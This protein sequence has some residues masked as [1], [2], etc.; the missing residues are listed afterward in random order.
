[1]IVTLTKEE[2]ADIAQEAY[3]YAGYD[4]TNYVGYYQIAVDADNEANNIVIA[5]NKDSSN[6]QH[7]YAIYVNPA[8][9][10]GYFEY[11]ETLDKQELAEKLMTIAQTY[12]ER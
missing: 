9:D 12:S 3:E 11:T 10:E 8:V 7:C 6:P 2:A 4:I 1:M 5:I